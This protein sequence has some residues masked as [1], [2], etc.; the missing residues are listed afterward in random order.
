MSSVAAI[1]MRQAR[2]DRGRVL[3]TPE[4]IALP[5]T[6]ASRGT[7]FGALALD[8]MIIGFLIV[9][10]TIGLLFI[11]GGTLSSI[12]N[13]HSAAGRALQFFAVLWLAAM[14]LFRNAYFLFFE[15]GPRGATLGKR[16]TGIRVAARDGGRLSAEMVI[17]RN[18]L[19]D[20]ELFL[21]LVFIA[22][23][24]GGG[25]MGAA[26]LAATAWFLLFALFP[27]FNKDR[28][29]AG[30][31]I[32]GT[33]VVEAPRR[34]LEAA[35]SAVAAPSSAD[36]AYKFGDPELAPYGEYEL[37]TLERVLREDRTEALVSV[38]EAICTKIGWTAPG[39]GQERAF[40]EAYYTQLRAHL[41]NGMRFGTRKADKFEAGLAKS[42]ATGTTFLFTTAELTVYGEPQLL[43]LERVLRESQD[44]TMTTV[45]E[46][47]ARKI[48]REPP[49]PSRQRA[50]LEAYYTQLKTRLRR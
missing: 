37:Q 15:L 36:H 45:A 12:E 44:P 18:L 6:L 29:R 34:K 50:F 9:G 46:S 30:D 14:F 28:L 40:L 42:A 10:T 21:P 2:S 33:W 38:A 48:G 39:L 43:S 26:S 3:I 5:L 17:A 16:M 20:I 49:D 32:A 23:A 31:L 8:L 41:E 19:R 1:P 22:S 13:N 47:I 11:A 35:M 7:R 4:G 25:D 24:S 27:C